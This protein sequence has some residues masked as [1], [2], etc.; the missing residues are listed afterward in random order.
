M[1]FMGRGNCQ[2]KDVIRFILFLSKK[3]KLSGHF[4]QFSLF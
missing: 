4:M 2:L 1:V 3:L